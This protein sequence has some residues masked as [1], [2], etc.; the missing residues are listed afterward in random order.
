MAT[1]RRFWREFAWGFFWPM[2]VHPR[3]LHGGPF[4][5]DPRDNC[6]GFRRDAMNLQGDARKVVGRLG[7]SGVVRVQEQEGQATRTRKT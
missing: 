7:T 6:E 4:P 2:N 5:E 3:P 1:F